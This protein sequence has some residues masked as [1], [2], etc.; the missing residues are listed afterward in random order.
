MDK[1]APEMQETMQRLIKIE[2]VAEEIE[3]LRVQNL[4]FNEKKEKNRECLGAFRRSEIQSDAKLWY[5]M[6]GDGNMM[7]KLPRKNAV[8]MIEAE[9][10]KLMK[11]IDETRAKIK[12]KTRELLKLSPNIS[13][14][15]PYTV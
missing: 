4:T 5:A 15:D 11:L 7:V 14:M 8:H 10:T 12:E 9:Q 3:S 1:I 2:R 13:D 6:G